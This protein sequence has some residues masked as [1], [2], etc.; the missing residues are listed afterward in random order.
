MQGQLGIE[1][2]ARHRP[3]VILLDLH[4]PDIAGDEVLRRLRAD[5]RTSEIPVIVLSADAIPTRVER[6]LREG[7]VDYVTKPIEI[8]RFLT[9]MRRAL[10]RP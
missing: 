1:L 7:I 8:D 10:G 3:D 5:E 6:L 4:L 9:A 2:A